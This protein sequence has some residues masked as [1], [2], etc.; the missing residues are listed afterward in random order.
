[1]PVNQALS[2]VVVQLGFPHLALG[3]ILLAALQWLI[4][5]WL[6]SRI[7]SSIK[8]EYDKKLAEY[9]Y[10]IK[11]REQAAIVA[12]FFTE[13]AR[14]EHADKSKLNRYSMDLSLW[15]PYEIYIKF[16]KCV[17]Y[18]PDAPKP[19]DILIEIRKYL[20]KEAAG[21]LSAE[22]IIHF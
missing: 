13:W 5:L 20:L 3:V 9:Q 17:C 14:G 8:H 4:S 15:L 18:A 11:I 21:N 10:E 2:N 16:G 6:K 1:M 19:K 7:E 22:Q 12:D